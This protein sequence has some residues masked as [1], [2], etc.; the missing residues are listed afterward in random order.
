MLDLISNT[1]FVLVLLLLCYPPMKQKPDT[2]FIVDYEQVLGR[3]GMSKH[4]LDHKA[5]DCVYDETA[6]P[7]IINSFAAA[8]YRFGHSLVQSIFR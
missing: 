8:A 7:S 6:D 2:I 4:Q 1:E 3:A 5:E